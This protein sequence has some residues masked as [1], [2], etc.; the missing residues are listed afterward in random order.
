MIK[1]EL[2]FLTEDESKRE[3]CRQ[4]WQLGERGKFAVSVPRL[5]E[6]FAVPRTKVATT[7]MP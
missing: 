2:E 3:L 5:A 6:T 4:Y 7:W 1:I